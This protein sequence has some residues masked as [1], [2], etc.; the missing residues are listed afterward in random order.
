[1]LARGEEWVL[2]F[3]SDNSDCDAIDMADY[4]DVI[5]G[6]DGNDFYCS[7][8]RS[9]EFAVPVNNQGELL[10]QAEVGL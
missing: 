2:V 1:M 10:T 8:G 4:P 6:L 3:V 7:G 9:V 5:T